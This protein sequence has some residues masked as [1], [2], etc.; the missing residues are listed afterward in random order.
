[1]TGSVSIIFFTKYSRAGASSRYRTLQ[2]IPYFERNGFRC[3]V[4]PLFDDA[5]LEFRYRYGKASKKAVLIAFFRRI[6]TLI[7]C[8]N[9]DVLVI[10]K[11]LFPYFPAFATSVLSWMGVPYVVDYDD[12]LFHQYDEHRLHLVRRVLGSK[13]S[14][15]MGGAALVVAGNKYLAEYAKKAGSPKVRVVPTVVDLESYPGP[16]RASNREGV[17]TIGWIGSPST[18]IYLE[19]IAP[20]LAEVCANG[21]ARVLLIGSGPCNL[22]GVPVGRIPGYEATEVE[23]IC[24][25]D[26]GVMPLPDDPWERGKCG[27]KLIQYMACE[28]PIVASPVGVNGEIVE[29]SHNGFLADDHDSW[30]RSLMALRDNPDL[31]SQMGRA[32]RAKVEN[33]YSLQVWAPAL[34]DLLGSNQLSTLTDR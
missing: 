9:F 10:E 16:I 18:T 34:A 23:N 15:V 19:M 21:V 17:F 28:L 11:E 24:K 26:V 2:Y 3:T 14:R 5:Y 31:C 29:D 20:A 22:A 1:M 33:Q 32:G 13:I 4:S 8:R 7:K 30:V 27:L 12:A 6:W 25:F